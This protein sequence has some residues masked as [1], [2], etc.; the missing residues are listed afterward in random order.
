MKTYSTKDIRNVV[1]IGSTRSGKTTLSEAMLY[2]GKVIDRRG[3]VE[4]KNT[5]SDNSEIEQLNQRSIYATPL[6]A[7]FMDTKF[8]IID[9]PGADDFVGGA[10][11]AF[12]VCDTAI[13][14]TNAQQG[15]EVGTEIFARYADNYNMPVI[16]G[17]NQL[18]GEK[19]NWENTLDG[20]KEAFGQKPVI[21][22]FPVNVGTGFDG[23]VDVLKMKYYHFKDDNGTRE[24]LEIP[25]ELQEQAEE[26]RGQLIERAAEFDD[27]LME[28]YFETGVLTEDEIRK[29]LGIGIRQLAIMPI[30]CLSA[31]KDIGVK[32]LMEFTIKVRPLLRKGKNTQKTEKK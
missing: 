12:R 9:A 32:R 28:K 26:L 24:D 22:Q 3:S 10:V 6:Y 27:G 25:A 15:V 8:N 17:I 30:F 18:D 5:V 7:E 23:F 13:L 31:K 16:L 21:V 4:A 14:V 19:A 29:G 11:S 1:L 20:L 2:E